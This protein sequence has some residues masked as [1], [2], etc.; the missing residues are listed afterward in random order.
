MANPNPKPAPPA[1]K[2]NRL[3]A[4]CKTSGQPRKL[5]DNDVKKLIQSMIDW[6]AKDS[7]LVF[8][9]WLGHNGLHY[10]SSCDLAERYPEY[11]ETLRRCKLIVAGRRERLAMEGKIEASIVRATL[12]TYDLEH[13]A[14]LRELKESALVE[15]A[16]A[17][18]VILAGR[19]AVKDKPKRKGNAK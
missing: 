2:G 1:P 13:R 8:N 5:N 3:A 10:Q 15:T 18:N 16:S 12:A 7:S 11:A 14:V 9:E 6:T 4:G 17:I 19:K